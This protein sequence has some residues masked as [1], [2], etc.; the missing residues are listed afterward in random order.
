MIL[1]ENGGRVVKD[2]GHNRGGFGS[3]G[4]SAFAPTPPSAPHGEFG[5]NG[6]CR[7]EALP[8][9][10][11]PVEPVWTTRKHERAFQLENCP[12]QAKTGLGWDIRALTDTPLIRK[13]RE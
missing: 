3:A 12:T 1:C 10:L 7:C 11:L 13:E 5:E 4:Q 6:L 2:V 9:V 8:A